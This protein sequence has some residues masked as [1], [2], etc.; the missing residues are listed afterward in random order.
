[1]MNQ[2]LRRSTNRPDSQRKDMVRAVGA[3][4]PWAVVVLSAH[5]IDTRRDGEIDRVR[6]AGLTIDP[7]GEQSSLPQT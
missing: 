7:V 4:L 3:L 5:L 6:D 1:M 2:T